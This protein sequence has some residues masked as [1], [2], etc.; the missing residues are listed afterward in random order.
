[1]KTSV[2]ILTYN[3][4]VFIDGALIIDATLKALQANYREDIEIIFVDNG[5]DDG[6][7]EKLKKFPFPHTL[8]SISGN[9]GISYGR[10]IGINVSRADDFIML[11][12]G[13]ISITPGWI[14]TLED[15]L[16]KKINCH[17]VNF[18]WNNFTRDPSKASQQITPDLVAEIARTE[19]LSKFAVTNGGLYRR[20]IFESGCMFP[21][22]GAFGLPGWGWEDTCHAFI[23]RKKGY[24]TD[25]FFNALKF[26]HPRS[27]S[28]IELEARGFSSNEAARRAA[29]DAYI[30]DMQL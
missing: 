26:W 22:H 29:L 27:H 23:M 5:S 25:I 24:R 15:Y 6:T 30:K 10:N 17:A 18:A 28:R 14:F 2:V 9:R 13:D 8:I 7:I 4:N 21:E 19:V 20:E 3:Y 12:D 1:M 16:T 11:L